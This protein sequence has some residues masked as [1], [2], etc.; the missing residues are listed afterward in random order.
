LASNLKYKT[1]RGINIETVFEKNAQTIYCSATS[2][3]KYYLMQDLHNFAAK[4]GGQTPL[5]DLKVAD[6]AILNFT[7]W[8]QAVKA[9]AII[10]QH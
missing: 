10:K 3:L 5:T 9:R 4:V 8:P 6:P 1:L 7:P 2:H